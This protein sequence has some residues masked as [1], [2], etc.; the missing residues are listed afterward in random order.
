LEQLQIRDNIQVPLE[1]AVAVRGDGLAVLKNHRWS[2]LGIGLEL[3]TGSSPN[4]SA[5]GLS[6]PV[7]TATV[8]V[9]NASQ[10]DQ[11]IVD[12][13]NAG[14]LAVVPD[15]RGGAYRWRWVGEEQKMPAPRPDHVIVLKPGEVHTFHVDFRDPA[16]SVEDTSPARRDLPAGIASLSDNKLIRRTLVEA[17]QDWS[18]RFRLEYRPPGRDACAGLS[19][20]EL[21][22]HGRLPTRAFS[23]GRVD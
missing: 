9:L 5:S 21:I 20:A 13:P 10:N 6:Q 22:W 4:N 11:A 19:H 8:R 1:M 15:L 7:L 23:G 18:A 12:L 2:A 16:W 14:S 3:Q 17:S